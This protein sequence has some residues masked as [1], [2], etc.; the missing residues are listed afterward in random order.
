MQ[1]TDTGPDTDIGHVYR[2][3]AIQDE[4]V[5]RPYIADGC[6]QQSRVTP[7]RQAEHRAPEPAHDVQPPAGEASSDFALEAEEQQHGATWRDYA[8]L[9]G[10]PVLVLLIGLGAALSGHFVFWR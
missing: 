10:V 2:T 7:T 9:L 3:G 6:T 1:A 8:A 4:R 5:R